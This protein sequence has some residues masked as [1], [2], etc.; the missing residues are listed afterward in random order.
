MLEVHY[1]AKSPFGPTL[2][3][4]STRVKDHKQLGAWLHNLLMTAEWPV[5][6]TAVVDLSAKFEAPFDGR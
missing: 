6:I 4:G 5:V 2:S 1:N 3:S